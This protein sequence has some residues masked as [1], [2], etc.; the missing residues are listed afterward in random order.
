[1]PLIKANNDV[2]TL[3]AADVGLGNVTN[4]SKA[5]MFTNPTFTG[6]VNATDLI[7]S[8]NLTVNGT[9]TT[10]NSTTVSVDD[11][12]IEL[13][14]VATP[15]N[16]TADGGGGGV[17]ANAARG[18]AGV[19]VSAPVGVTYYGYLTENGGQGGP[20]TN[21]ARPTNNGQSRTYAGGGGGGSG[22]T[23][24]SIGGLGGTSTFGG[25]GGNGSNGNAGQAGSTPGQRCS[26]RSGSSHPTPAS[27]C[28]RHPASAG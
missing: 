8:G 23:S 10:I 19:V 27:P 5:T 11:K 24:G 14:S 13:G 25:A 21:S 17:T 15:T 22:E 1:M 18:L 3:T 28:S 4:E 26:P 20:G 16:T 2:V 6:T 7:L 12:N 9:T